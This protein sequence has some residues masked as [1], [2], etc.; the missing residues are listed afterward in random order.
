M[1]FPSLGINEDLPKVKK[2]KKKEANAI[3]IS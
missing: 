1:G 2:E 3:E